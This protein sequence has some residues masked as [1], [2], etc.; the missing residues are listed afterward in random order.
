MSDL[1]RQP[2]PYPKRTPSKPSSNSMP[3]QER[4]REPDRQAR[5]MPRSRND[6]PGKPI[7]PRPLP[8]FKR[9]L[10]KRPVLPYAQETHEAQFERTERLRALR[11]D[12]LEHTQT[13]V[14]PQKPRNVILAGAMTVVLLLV[15]IVGTVAFFQLKP[16]LFAPN[17]QNVAI[18]F[19]D[20]MKNGDYTGAFSNCASSVQ[21]L[22]G[23]QAHRLSQQDFIAQAKAADKTA[24][25]ITSYTQ[26][27]VTPLDAN[28]MQYT[29]TI[30]RNH[31]SIRDVKVVVT[32]GT[33]GSWK[34]SNIDSAL[35]TVPQPPATTPSP[36]TTTTPSA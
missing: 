6:E 16:I 27:G 1:Q 36:N 12:F 17:G 18:S 9:S 31:T 23:T 26:T 4:Q 5:Q 24:G 34:I 11:Q 13:K 35:L 14:A 2:G 25:S 19:L 20:A 32:K 15:C 29:Y 28:T 10:G 3:R 22:S 21:E 7:R 33:D 30:T 8:D